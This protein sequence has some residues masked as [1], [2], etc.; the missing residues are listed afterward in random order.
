MSP[1][2]FQFVRSVIAG[3]I[4]TGVSIAVLYVLTEYVGF[5]YLLSSSIAYLVALV[6]N[7]TLQKYW[8]YKDSGRRIAGQFTRYVGLVGINFVLNLT[9]LYVLTDWMGLWYIMSQFIV[10]GLLFVFNFFVGRKYIFRAAS[11]VGMEEA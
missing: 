5:H 9:F 1:T 11:H 6:T 10:T 2:V 3:G 8:V 7:F 4:T